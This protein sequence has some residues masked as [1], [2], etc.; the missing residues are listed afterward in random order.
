MCSQERLWATP[1][2]SPPIQNY[3]VR[4]K[5]AQR[6]RIFERSCLISFRWDVGCLGTTDCHRTKQFAKRDN[7]SGS[8]FVNFIWNLTRYFRK[9]EELHGGAGTGLVHNELKTI[10]SKTGCK[11]PC[12]Y[13]QYGFLNSDL[14]PESEWP[15]E[16][17]IQFGLWAVTN[18]TKIEKEVLLYPFTSLLAEFGGSLG[19]FLGFSIMTIWDCAVDLIERVSKCLRIDNWWQK[20]S[21]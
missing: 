9:F 5:R 15:V 10:I 14:K 1:G 19:L 17:Q 6:A 8:F 13:N 2:E 3:F 11:A 20:Q 7:S 16:G 12:Q 4:I 18:L 21:M